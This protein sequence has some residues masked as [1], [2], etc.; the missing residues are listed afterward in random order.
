MVVVG[1]LSLIVQHPFLPASYVF[2]LNYRFNVNGSVRHE[3]SH[4]YPSRTG[5]GPGYQV[6]SNLEAETGRE[7]EMSHRDD[8][9]SD[10]ASSIEDEISLN[11]LT[12]R[13]LTIDDE[14][15]QVRSHRSSCSG[16]DAF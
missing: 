6:K 16:S 1:D 14:G 4:L 11:D 9:T 2:Q 15:S 5:W 7:E 13:S 10:A 12:A 8:L 3:D